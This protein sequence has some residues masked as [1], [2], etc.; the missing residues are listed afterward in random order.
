MEEIIKILK[1]TNNITKNN[2]VKMLLKTVIVIFI[3]MALSIVTSKLNL[4]YTLNETFIENLSSIIKRSSI[5]LLLASLKG[6]FL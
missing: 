4:E 1:K 3:A 6:L 2:Y 5:F